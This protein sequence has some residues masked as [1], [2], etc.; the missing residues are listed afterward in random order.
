MYRTLLVPLDG[1]TEAELPLRSIASLV[2]REGA[3]VLLV[4]SVPDP[5][6]EAGMPTG[7]AQVRALEEAETYLHS[8]A[9]RLTRAGVDVSA[10]TGMGSFADVIEARA[11]ADNVDVILMATHGRWGMDRLV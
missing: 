9:T 3:R 8:V 5:E 6:P 7:P 11:Q 10:I 1:S 4:R 2:K